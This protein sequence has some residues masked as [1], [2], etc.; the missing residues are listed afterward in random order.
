M[1]R[2]P[3]EPALSCCSHKDPRF[4]SLMCGRHRLPKR[5]LSYSNTETQG[6]C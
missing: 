1:V 2:E 5:A 3:R 6:D 4:I